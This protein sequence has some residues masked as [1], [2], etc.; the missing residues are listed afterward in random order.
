MCVS[1]GLPYDYRPFYLTCDREWLNRWT[2]W[3]CESMIRDGLLCEV[4]QLETIERLSQQS[5]QEEHKTHSKYL[6]HI[7]MQEG[8]HAAPVVGK[9]AAFLLVAK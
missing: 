5:S 9:R 6:K 3:R 2:D 4:K 8:A 7:N 1:K